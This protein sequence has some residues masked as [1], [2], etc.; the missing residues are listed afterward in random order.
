MVKDDTVE[1]ELERKERA[2]AFAVR[3]CDVGGRLFLGSLGKGMDSAAGAAS[4]GVH[5]RGWRR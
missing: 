3:R 4:G 5:V 1:G 2:I